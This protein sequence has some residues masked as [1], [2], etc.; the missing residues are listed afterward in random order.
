MRPNFQQQAAWIAS[1]TERY[2]LSILFLAF[3]WL[4][5]TQAVLSWRIMHYGGDQANLAYFIQHTI[6]VLVNVSIGAT[7]LFGQQIN[8]APQSLEEILVPLGATFFYLVYSCIDSL[9]DW[10]SDNL[11]PPNWQTP[12]AWLGLAIG[13][14]GRII[15]A[16]GAFY[17]GRS[18]GIFVSVRDV[19]LRGPYRYVRHPIYLGYLLMFGGLTLAYCCAALFIIVPAHFGLFAWRVRLEESRLAESS[20]AYREYIKHTGSIFPRLSTWKNSP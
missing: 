1:F 17:L 2:I 5:V 6:M 9:P 13:I 20:P 4:E 18:F 10:L 8:A 11:A 19:V 12:I 16:W 15:V 3:A 14:F 7:L